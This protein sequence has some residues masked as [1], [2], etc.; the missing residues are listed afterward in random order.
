MT[1]YFV[2][3]PVTGEAHFIVEAKN[4]KEAIEKAGDI[5]FSIIT[6]GHNGEDVSLDEIETHV[7]PINKG[8]IFYGSCGEPYADENR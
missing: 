8:N 5:Q 7:S 1:E 4:E 2:C 3:L 6:K